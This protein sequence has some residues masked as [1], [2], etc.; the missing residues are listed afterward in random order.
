M[1]L[2]LCPGSGSSR[3]LWAV[4]EPSSGRCVRT[5]SSCLGSRLASFALRLR[6]D[7]CCSCV[8]GQGCLNLPGSGQEMV[9]K[10]SRPCGQGA[11]KPSLAPVVLGWHVW[12]PKGVKLSW[13]WGRPGC[14]SAA[15]LW[16]LQ[17]DCSLHRDGGFP[18]VCW[19]FCQQT[20]SNRRLWG[21]KWAQSLLGIRRLN[22]VPALCC[23]RSL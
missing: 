6:F 17:R 2:S 4:R 1:V 22:S 19:S 11:L 15:R 16:I 12:L 18:A 8:P 7:P 20:S 3:S 23:L 21:L 13:P 5:Y 14:E 9:L 10:G